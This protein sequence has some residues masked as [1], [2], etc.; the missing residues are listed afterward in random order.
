MYTDT[1]TQTHAKERGLTSE[2]SRENKGGG[3]RTTV[4]MQNYYGCA[5]TNTQ[6]SS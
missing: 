3:V 1:C 4:L 6:T 5:N 2:G